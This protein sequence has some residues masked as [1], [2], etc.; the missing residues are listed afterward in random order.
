MLARPATGYGFIEAAKAQIAS[1]KSVDAL[2]AAQALLLPLE[3]GLSIEQTA[4][5]IGL[6]KSQTTKIRTRFQRVEMGTEPPKAE[7]RRRNHARMTLVEEK[8]L[9]APFSDKDQL[10]GTSIAST[11]RA[12]MERQLGHSVALSTVYR[13][14]HRHGW[15]KVAQKP[16]S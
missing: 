10:P 6:S 1:T 11:L 15:R 7:Q 2:R 16:T 14:L 5:V 3:F 8:S 9:L 4:I 13:L 12:E